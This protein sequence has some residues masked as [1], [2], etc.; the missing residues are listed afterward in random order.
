MIPLLVSVLLLPLFIS[1]GWIIKPL[2]Y[3]LPSSL[4][5]FQQ[6]EFPYGQLIKR[7]FLDICF[8]DR[9][10]F[11]PLL[12]CVLCESRKTSA[13]TEMNTHA[14]SQS[15]TLQLQKSK[16]VKKKYPNI[17]FQHFFLYSTVLLLYNPNQSLSVH[18]KTSDR[19]SAAGMVQSL[20]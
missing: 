17:L 19:S 20:I 15:S 4:P 5:H 11:F 18:C 13:R 1:D 16:K 10:H 14:H 6:C 12:I 7:P 3:C 9:H 8:S 2:Q